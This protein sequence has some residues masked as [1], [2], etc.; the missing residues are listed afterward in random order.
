MSLKQ[1]RI[2]FI[3][4]LRMIAML[5]VLTPHLLAYRIEN[6]SMRMLAFYV[7]NRL[8]IIQFG[9]ALGVS[10]FFLTSG[11]LTLSQIGSGHYGQR[12]YKQIVV[13]IIEAFIA[14]MFCMLFSKLF[15]YI[16]RSISIYENYYAKYTLIDWVASGLLIRNLLYLESTEGALWFLIPFL[17]Y[18]AMLL[19]FDASLKKNLNHREEICVWMFYGLFALGYCI[20]HFYT[21]VYY[22]TERFFYIGIILIGYIF[23]LLHNNKINKNRFVLLQFFNLSFMLYGLEKTQVGIDDGYI[24]SV[25]Y[26]TVLFFIFYKLKDS[27]Q[28]NSIISYFD[29]IGIS[30][31]LL[32]NCIGFNFIQLIYNVLLNGLFSEKRALASLT[33]S[34][35]FTMIII[36]IYSYCISSHIRQFLRLNKKAEIITP[37]LSK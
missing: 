23:S 19:L 27:F 31:F 10:L 21:P 8:H 7:F 33:L 9:G 16:F 20:K 28:T 5:C 1:P 34:V 24:V 22:L 37:P 29:K 26:A 35:V 14:M 30:F 18:K 13:V 17:F 2:A 4:I 36:T 11:Y 12:I 3:S 25:I 15:E 6:I 32:H